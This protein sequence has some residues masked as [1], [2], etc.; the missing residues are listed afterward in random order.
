MYSHCISHCIYR[1]YILIRYMVFI[2]HLM[3][4]ENVVHVTCGAMRANG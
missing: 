1:P 2:L 3:Y 4:T